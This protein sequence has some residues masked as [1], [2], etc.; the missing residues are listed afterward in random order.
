MSQNTKTAAYAIAALA[1]VGAL[2][3]VTPARAD[4]YRPSAFTVAQGT[5]PSTTA[6]S[7]TEPTTAPAPTAAAPSSGSVM[8]VNSR[9]EAHIKDLHAKLKITKDQEDKWKALADVMRENASEM[10]GL[11]KTRAENAKSM[12]A[13]D[14]LNAYSKI[15]D[16]HAE[17]LKKFIA[18]FSTLYDSMSDAQKKNADALFRSRIH[19]RT[20]QKAS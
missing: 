12:S 16:A 6:P 19:A 15:T 1:L 14:D 2:A 18:A 9:L 17:G 8:P 7:T 13:V 4:A 20:K 10:E 3:V 11:V 5:T